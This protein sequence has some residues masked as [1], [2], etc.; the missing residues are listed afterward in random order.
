M[1]QDLELEVLLLAL[2]ERQEVSVDP[3]RGLVDPA[4]VQG[5]AGSE[6]LLVVQLVDLV[7]SAVTSLKLFQETLVTTIPSSLKFH[8]PHLFVM[9]KLR[10]AIMPTL[11]QTARHSTSAPLT[12]RLASPS[13][14]SSVPMGLC[15]IRNILSAIGGSMLIVP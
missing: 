7:E 4:G 11:T 5:P 1:E 10:V 13:I 2:L 15:S 6:D 9:V 8:Q 12:L 3:L 14:A